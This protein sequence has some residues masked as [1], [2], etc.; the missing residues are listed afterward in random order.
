M[1]ANRLPIATK[2][3]GLRKVIIIRKKNHFILKKISN[4]KFFAIIIFL[5]PRIMSQEVINL[6]NF[7]RVH[8]IFTKFRILTSV[9]KWSNTR[10]PKKG[11]TGA[12]ILVECCP[13]AIH[14]SLRRAVKSR[15]PFPI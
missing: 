9:V 13:A 6:L 7:C 4:M 1:R 15:V 8:L 2:I 5:L 11:N 14:Y 10:T 3:P 12:T